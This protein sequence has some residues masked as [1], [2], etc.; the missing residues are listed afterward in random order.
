MG[1]TGPYQSGFCGS[2]RA[3]ALSPARITPPATLRRFKCATS[4]AGHAVQGPG[5]PKRLRRRSDRLRRPNVASSTSKTRPHPQPH[6]RRFSRGNKPA[7]IRLARRISPN[8]S[9]R[10]DLSHRPHSNPD[11]ASRRPQRPRT[12]APSPIPP[13]PALPDRPALSSVP[14]EVPPAEFIGHRTPAEV[15]SSQFV[16]ESPPRTATPY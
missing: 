5:W 3:P 13:A 10:N 4:C 7:E 14:R 9:P 8:S 12:R 16:A 1:R 2:H 6:L 15:L 11:S